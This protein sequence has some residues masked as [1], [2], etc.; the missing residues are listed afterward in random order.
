LKN[1]PNIIPNCYVIDSLRLPIGKQGGMYKRILPEQL[2]GFLIK[3]LVA[4]NNIEPSHIEQVILGAALGTGGNMARYAALDAGLPHMVFASTVD[5]QC[6]S[7]LAAIA[8]GWRAVL[9][10]ANI[11]LAGG[12]ESCSLAPKR[13]YAAQDPR[14]TGDGSYEQASFAPDA[15]GAAGLFEAASRVAEQYGFSKTKLQQQS[16]LSHQRAIQA[17]DNT[18][19]NNQIWPWQNQLTDQ[20]PRAHLSLEK[21]QALEKEPLTDFTTAAPKADAAAVAMLASE[22][23]CTDNNINP[24]YRICHIA[25]VGLEPSSAPLATLAAVSKLLA[26]AN[27]PV[28]AVGLFEIGESF[29]VNPLVFAQK[30]DIDPAKINIFGGNL[31]YGHP[32]GASGA[33]LFGHLLAA[34]SMANVQYGIAALPAAGGLGIAVLVERI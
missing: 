26:L 3:N 33:I 2:A 32:F 4:K 22:Q 23:Y 5:S 15:Y 19:F 14:F 17:Q 18:Y 29:A 7:G 13:Q 28:T 24:S 1:N 11:V 27:M 16:I 34:M 30:F 31:A 21:L 12:M 6:V 20:S 10:G 9:N 8:Q 25:E